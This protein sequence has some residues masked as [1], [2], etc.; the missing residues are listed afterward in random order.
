MQHT[1]KMPVA[2]GQSTQPLVA[3]PIVLRNTAWVAALAL[4]SLVSVASAQ[5]VVRSQS[6]LGHASFS[7][8]ASPSGNQDAAQPRAAAARLPAALQHSVSRYP[9]TLYASPDCNGCKLGR[10]LLEHR[11]IPFQEYRIT[12]PEEQRAASN[13]GISTLPHLMI[14]TQALKGYDSQDWANYLS[15]AG[16]PKTSVLPANYQAPAVKSVLPDAPANP[17]NANTPSESPSALDN[18]VPS[19]PGD[20][21]S[22]GFR[23]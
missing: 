22:D 1:I 23:F 4:S 17:A 10:E 16:Y 15:A 5:A 14:G 11:G 8:P 7:D 9:V 6:T 13:L 20:A 19:R 21:P 2:T 18:S 12:S 3:S